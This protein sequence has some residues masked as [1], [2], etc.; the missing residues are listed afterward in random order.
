MMNKQRFLKFMTDEIERQQKDMY[1]SGEGKKAVSVLIQVYTLVSDGKF[2]MQGGRGD[3]ADEI[4]RVHE[5]RGN[6][7]SGIVHHANCKDVH[8]EV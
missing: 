7:K 5:Q 1:K 3:V 6:L 4:W 8:M 2:D